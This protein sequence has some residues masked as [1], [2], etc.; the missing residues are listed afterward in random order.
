MCQTGISSLKAWQTEENDDVNF[1]FFTILC[2]NSTEN[3]FQCARLEFL[4]RT[5]M[6]E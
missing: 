1:F 4:G 3:L 2:F 5:C 6:V